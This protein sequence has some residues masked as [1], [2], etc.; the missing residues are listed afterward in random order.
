VEMELYYTLTGTTTAP[1]SNKSTCHNPVT[2][3]SFTEGLIFILWYS[4]GLGDE[5]ATLPD[6]TGLTFAEA[7]QVLLRAKLRSIAIGIDEEDEAEQTVQ[8]QSPQPGT[9][10]RTGFEVRLDR[11]SVVEGRGGAG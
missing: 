4:T 9:Q 1:I 6:V 8:R 10:V 2:C 11:K 5:Y 3:D 7:R